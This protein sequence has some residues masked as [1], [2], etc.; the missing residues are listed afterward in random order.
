MA[1]ALTGHGQVVAAILY[2]IRSNNKITMLQEVFKE[3]AE[4]DVG[5]AVPLSRHLD[6]GPPDMLRFRVLPGTSFAQLCA[7]L[8]SVWRT[9]GH[10]ARLVSSSVWRYVT[11]PRAKLQRRNQRRNLLSAFLLCAL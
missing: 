9:G 8:V 2:S 10:L 11:V 7:I 4:V 3:F 5:C 6:G 1:V